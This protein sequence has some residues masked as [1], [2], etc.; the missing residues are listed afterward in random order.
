MFIKNNKWKRNSYRFFWIFKLVQMLL[1][2]LPLIYSL[3]SHLRL[4]KIFE[5]YVQGNMVMWEWV[6]KQRNFI[7]SILLFIGLWMVCVYKVVILLMQMELEY[8]NDFFIYLFNFKLNIRVR[9]YMVVHLLMRIFNEDIHVLDYYLWQIREEI[10][11]RHNFLS[12]WKHALIWM[13]S[14]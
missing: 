14:M 8:Y 7:I 6:R 11:I 2:E 10:Q 1:V 12:H 13:E 9:Q 4:Q 5:D 3:I